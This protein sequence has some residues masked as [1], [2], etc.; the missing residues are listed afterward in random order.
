MT[1]QLSYVSNMPSIGPVPL[2]GGDA[3]LLA[4]AALLVAIV[5][6]GWAALLRALRRRFRVSAVER[7]FT[8]AEDA[9]YR[10]L[11]PLANEHGAVVFAKVGLKDL[12]RDRPGAARGQFFRYA[13][14]HVDFLIVS[15]HDFRPLVG[16]ELDGTSHRAPVQHARD[17]KKDAVFKAAGLPLLRF[18]NGIAVQ[19]VRKRLSPVLKEA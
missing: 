6:V 14:L 10:D 11:Q 7:F 13:Q 8:K 16:V 15:A 5:C 9:F 3:A 1:G 18:P 19:D 2:S 17:R 12:F 4:A